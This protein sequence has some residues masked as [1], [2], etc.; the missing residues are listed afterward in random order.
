MRL[1]TLLSTVSLLFFTAC[2]QHFYSPNFIHTPYIDQ[3][4]QGAITAAVSGSPISINGDFHV[5]YSPIKHGTAMLNVFRSQTSFE[6]TNF[7]GGTTYRERSKGF[8]AEAAVGGYLPF[9]FGT[10]ALYVGWG[11][12]QT[13]NDYG[14]GRI[15]ELS[16]QRF[17]IQPSF[18][19]KND[20]FRLGMGMRLVYLAFPKGRV[21]YRI[22]QEDI[23]V[24]QRLEK[25]APLWFPEF[26]GNIGVHIKP[27]TIHADLVLIAAK[28]AP[29]YGFDGSNIGLGLTV[30]LE[31]LFQSKSR[32]E[33][34]QKPNKH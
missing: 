19:F 7:F 24:I 23:Q 30:E 16:L 32:E 3:K 12:G 1:F 15:A 34:K 2:N 20:W 8:L 33:K 11:L 29:E 26:G 17:S 28:R 10:G 13:R 6:N 27:V 31:N 4:G 22:D 5:S 14:I 9:G 21:D 18:T 25:E